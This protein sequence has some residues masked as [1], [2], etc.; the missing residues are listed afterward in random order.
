MSGDDNSQGPAYTAKLLHWQKVYAQALH[1]DR[2]A[3]DIGLFTMK[4]VMVINGGALVALMVFLR[5]FTGPGTAFLRSATVQAIKLFLLGLLLA[6]LAS[7]IAYINQNAV[8]ANIWNDLAKVTDPK[9]K[10]P[11]PHT[12]KV[13]GPL[14]FAVIIL[15]VVAYGL[16]AAGAWTLLTA[17]DP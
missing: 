10:I 9:A 17:L 1:S 4:V 8:T 6:A 7:G 11:Q 2:A 3:V 13:A 14:I 16:F 12:E 15:T 5:G